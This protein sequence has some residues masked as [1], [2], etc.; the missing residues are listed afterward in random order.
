MLNVSFRADQDSHAEVWSKRRAVSMGKVGSYGVPNQRLRAVPNEGK[1]E[2]E[3]APKYA[4]SNNCENAGSPKLATATMPVWRRSHRI[5]QSPAVMA[6]AGSARPA[7]DYGISG[8]VTDR[9]SSMSGGE[10]WQLVQSAT[11]SM[12]LRQCELTNCCKS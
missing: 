12:R 2:N 11:N 10:G 9:E 6:W 5:T 7:T 1:K 3:S 4:A 8:Q